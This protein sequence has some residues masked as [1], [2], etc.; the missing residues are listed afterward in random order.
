MPRQ[1]KRPV[2][3]TKTIGSYRRE[4]RSI[5]IRTILLAALILVGIA[6]IGL[7]VFQVAGELAPWRPATEISP[8]DARKQLSAG[9]VVL[10]VRTHDE[11]IAGHIEKSLLMPLE[12]LTSLM[13]ALPRNQ[14]IIVVCRTGVRSMQARRILLEA[15]LTQVTSLKGG[16][17]A[18][19]AAGFP[20]VYGEPIRNN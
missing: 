13:D 6:G 15:G 16:M 9:A 1:T 3:S 10:D 2:K 14:L 4:S 5:P 12:E 19:I 18:W 17:E 7:L 8:D 20:L 11:F